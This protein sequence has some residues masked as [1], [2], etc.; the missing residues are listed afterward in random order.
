MCGHGVTY[1]DISPGILLFSVTPV[2]RSTSSTVRGRFMCSS[3]LSSAPAIIRPVDDDLALD[4]LPIENDPLMF[5]RTR[6]TVSGQIGREH[7]LRQPLEAVYLSPHLSQP[8][9]VRHQLSSHRCSPFALAS[10]LALAAAL[11]F[12]T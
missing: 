9:G 7:F 5:R 8:G 3:P 2:V 11:A 6:P 12:L 10:A 4:D 1:T